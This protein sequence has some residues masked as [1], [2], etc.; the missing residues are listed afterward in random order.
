MT[1]EIEYKKDCNKAYGEQLPELIG[2][3]LFEERLRK[4]KTIRM[5]SQYTGISE[6]HIDEAEIARRSMR[7]HVIARLLK[8]YGKRFEVRLVKEH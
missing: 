7:W 2:R 4:N 8:Y 1:A 6:R 3:L 5:V